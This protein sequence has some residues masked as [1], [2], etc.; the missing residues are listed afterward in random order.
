M[1]TIT[2]PARKHP[3]APEPRIAPRYRPSRLRL[4]RRRP[5]RLRRGALSLA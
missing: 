5:R 3:R 1:S 4:L 2:N